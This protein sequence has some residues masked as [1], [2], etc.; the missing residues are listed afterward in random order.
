MV[1]FGTFVASSLLLLS[2]STYA[3]SSS[4]TD[5]VNTKK[6]HRKVE[7]L[8]EEFEKAEDSR[9]KTRIIPKP[10]ENLRFTQS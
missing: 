1:A 6:D 8:V 9:S 4:S 2:P 7:E 5:I 3:Q 10:C